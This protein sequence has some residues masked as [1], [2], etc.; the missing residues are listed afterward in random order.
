MNSAKSTRNGP[1][2]EAPV[3]VPAVTERRYHDDPGL[4]P[5]AAAKRHHTDRFRRTKGGSLILEKWTNAKSGY[6]GYLTGRGHT[7]IEIA[8]ILADGTI[9]ETIRGVWRRWGLPRTE[10]N[11]LRCVILQIPL[12]PTQR[13]RIATRARAVGITPEEWAWRVLIC[14]ASGDLYA[15]ITDGRFDKPADK[16][17]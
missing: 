8:R 15:A 10:T 16:R 3:D 2:T 6:V 9:P 14:A 5:G 13:G 17:S 4:K 7:S 12:R 11:G 1:M